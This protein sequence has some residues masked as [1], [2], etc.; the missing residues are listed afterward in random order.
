MKLRIVAA[1][2]A[3][4][5]FVGGAAR[6]DQYAITVDWHADGIMF[7][8]DD[9][10]DYCAA[11]GCSEDPSQWSVVGENVFTE[12]SDT[13]NGDSINLG[14][15]GSVNLQSDGGVFYSMPDNQDGF[16]GRDLGFGGGW[17][18]TNV[19]DLTPPPIVVEPPPVTPVPEPAN[20]ALILAG[21]GLIGAAARRK[22]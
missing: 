16:A 15:G 18:V 8:P 19:T 6:A 14:N 10:S 7:A 3:G 11:V 9:P 12:A 13:F 4:L 1:V 20:V 22:A 21:L 17:N 5:V 2:A